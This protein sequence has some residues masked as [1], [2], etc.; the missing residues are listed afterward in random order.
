MFRRG[1]ALCEMA[2]ALAGALLAETAGMGL[3]ERELG[4]RD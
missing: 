1:A 2:Q 3:Q 4:R